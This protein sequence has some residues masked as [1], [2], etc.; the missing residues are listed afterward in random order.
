MTRIAL[1]IALA[2]AALF[3]AAGTAH[4]TTRIPA[5]CVP[6]QAITTPFVERVCAIHFHFRRTNYYRGLGG[7]A[8]L[9]YYHDAEQHPSRSIKILSFW[10]AAQDRAHTYLTEVYV[11]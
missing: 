6:H 3:A 2:A 10:A 11:P 4:A 7:L 1:T 8:P 9:P 5:R